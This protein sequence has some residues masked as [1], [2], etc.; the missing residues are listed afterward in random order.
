MAGFVA[1][2]DHD[3]EP[4]PGGLLA[5]PERAVA[6]A[7][8]VS[9]RLSFR[10]N[11]LG[12]RHTPVIRRGTGTRATSR[13]VDRRSLREGGQLGQL[14]AVRLARSRQPFR[15]RPSGGAQGLELVA[16]PSGLAENEQTGLGAR[17]TRASSARRAP[18]AANR[19]ARTWSTRSSRGLVALGDNQRRLCLVRRHS[20]LSCG[21]RATADRARAV[22]DA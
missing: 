10:V 3:S 20:S 4:V 5:P 6:F 18:Y 13:K 7:E 14:R 16:R 2:L 8:S 1:G 21:F 11:H 17:V 12:A 9:P 22:C 15:L 19:S